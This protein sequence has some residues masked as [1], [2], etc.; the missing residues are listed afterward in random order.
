MRKKTIKCMADT[1]FWYVLY[2]MPVI[3]YLL[4]MFIHPSGSGSIT[5]LNFMTFLGDTGF[6]VITDNVIYQALYEIF[7]TGGI[8]PFFDSPVIFA[9]MT[10]YVAVF[11]LHL[12]VDFCLFIPRLAH[13]WL[14]AFTKADN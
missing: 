9:C 1:I 12:F 8:L 5:P 4:F 3:S 7:G 11:I 13:K 2:F 14:D 10:W 6:T